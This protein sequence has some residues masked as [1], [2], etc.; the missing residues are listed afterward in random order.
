VLSLVR[1]LS[2]LHLLLSYA[3]R[4][5]RISNRSY[6]IYSTRFGEQT[7]CYSTLAI[8]LSAPGASQTSSNSD[9]APTPTVAIV[10]KIFT[11][12]YTLQPVGSSGKG[13]TAKLGIGIGVG[14]GVVVI[15]AVCF[16]LWRW[17]LWKELQRGQHGGSQHQAPADTENLEL[18]AEGTKPHPAQPELDGES[19]KELPTQPE[20]TR[21][22]E[23]AVQ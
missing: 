21:P 9:S 17:K 3:N 1:T 4:R 10:D 8:P 11:H 22:I 2:E 12:K 15:L 7:P 6:S 5:F 23:L 16:F 14:A 13:E 20:P 18:D 19:R